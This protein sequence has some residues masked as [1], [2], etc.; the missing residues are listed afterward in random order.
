MHMRKSLLFLGLLLT[1]FSSAQ[2]RE[3]AYLINE[4]LGK[5][6]NF[7]N[8]FEAPGETDWGNPWRPHYPQLVAELGFNH[9]RIPIRWEPES[10]SSAT[11]PYTIN[12]AFL[13]RIKQVVDSTLNNGL[14]AIINMHHHEALYENP[15]AQKARFLAQWKQISE[16]FSHY[17]DSLLFEVLNEPHGNLTAEKWNTFL[18]DA[19][20]T[21]RTS[22][23]E[24][25]VLIGTAEYG[26]LG[27]LQKLQL[28]DDENIIL[29]AHYYNP[30][31]F[32]HQGAEWSEGAEAWLG[33]EWND[34][35]TERRVVQNDFAPLKAIELQKSIPVHIG[36]FGAYNKAD[37]ASR[38][39]WTTYLARFIES[40]GW[41]W[42]YWEFSAG[43]GIYNPASSS[44]NPELIDALLTRQ[45]PNP[46]S[47]VGTP[48]YSSE[49]IKTI[50]DWQL[51][52]NNGAL[53]EASLSAG[54]LEINI[55]E[56]GTEGWHIQLAK[57]N[58]ALQAGEKYRLTF[59]AKAKQNRNA[60]SYVGMSVS[61]WNSY[62]GYNNIS[63]SDTFK[64]YSF[65]FD[66]TT[67]DNTARIVFDL[68]TDIP[69]VSIEYV[70]LEKV[71]LQYPT[72]VD[73]E[74]LSSS[75]VFPNPLNEKLNI[76][77]LNNF[78]QLTILNT[79]GQTLLQTRLA[80]QLNTIQLNK[81][82]S[83]MY[84]VILSSQNKRESIKIIKK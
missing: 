65:I 7:G 4:Q 41:S 30:F 33:T 17:P 84:F 18:T 69:D 53:A 61:P 52:A 76:M 10:R 2:N 27:G 56:K 16:Y 38:V 29:T 22:N 26:G 67:T 70:L 11:A 80:P 49:F 13:E 3:K 47:Y 60:T 24:R 68:G 8:M 63:L 44:F 72:A 25:V 79:N 36:E 14:F 19:L 43:F 55:S 9:V 77:N 82:P 37:L 12:E 46:T 15:E 35:E 39:R 21:I 45:L 64:V 54:A 20:R 57:N 62:S 40:Q 83:G 48:V 58:L 59:K 78:E 71:A 73:N 50:S 34:T 81:I 51:H 31:T 75:L 28:P 1:I 23:P 42:A 32:T 6:I 74:Q 5:G 66:M